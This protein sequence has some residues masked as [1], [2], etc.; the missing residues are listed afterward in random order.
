MSELS[1][2]SESADGTLV[3]HLVARRNG[4]DY[5]VRY[6]APNKKSSDFPDSKARVTVTAYDYPLPASHF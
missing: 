6:E 1:E 4:Y 2:A 5:Y 3:A